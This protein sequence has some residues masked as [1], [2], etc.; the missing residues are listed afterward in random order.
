MSGIPEIPA[1]RL[2]VKPSDG[3]EKGACVG[4]DH[5]G[6][7]VYFG[8]LFSAISFIDGFQVMLVS[9]EDMDGLNAFLR[10]NEGSVH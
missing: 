7:I 10:R 1:G 9:P 5:N 4:I 2:L 8:P 6:C 3:L